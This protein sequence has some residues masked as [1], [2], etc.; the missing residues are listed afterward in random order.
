MASWVTVTKGKALLIL[1]GTV[2]T[3]FGA[4][5]DITSFPETLHLISARHI[6]HILIILGGHD[7]KRLRTAGDC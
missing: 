1:K 5:Y 6:L 7:S 3:G 2:H 4:T